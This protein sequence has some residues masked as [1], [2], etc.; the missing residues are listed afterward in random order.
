M[1]SV[2]RPLGLRQ[3]CNVLREATRD[4]KYSETFVVG[5]GWFLCGHANKSCRQTGVSDVDG[6]ERGHGSVGLLALRMRSCW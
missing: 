2:H 6:R 4:L 1:A 5:E 3:G